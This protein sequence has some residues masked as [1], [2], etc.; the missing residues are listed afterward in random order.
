MIQDK[1]PVTTI[2]VY[3]DDETLV[4]ATANIDVVDAV[5]DRSLGFTATF[6]MVADIH[7]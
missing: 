7:L 3:E 1:M 5:D 2:G 6:A 4:A